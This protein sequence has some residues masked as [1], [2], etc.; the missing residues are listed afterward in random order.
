[1]RFRLR[2]LFLA[3][4][5]LLLDCAALDK[6]PETTCGN[7]VVD[8]AEDCDTFPS[9][10]DPTKPRCG[11]PTEGDFACHLHCG[12]ADSGANVCPAGWGCDTSG[13][14]REPSGQFSSALG[15]VS[16]GAVRLTVGDFDGDGRKDLVASGPRNPHSASSVRV[17]YFDDLGALAQVASLPTAVVSPAVFDHDHN[18]RDAIAFGVPAASSPKT[19]ASSLGVVSGLADRTF[20]PVVFPAATL[21]DTNAVPVFVFD[22][23]ADVKLP[24]GSESAIILFA[25]D[26]NGEAIVSLDAEL[27]GTAKLTR[28]LPATPDSIR[29]RPLTAR[30]FDLDATS[31]C[32]EIIVAMQVAPIGKLLVLSPCTPAPK[33]TA[34]TRWS[35]APEALKPFDLPA[36]ADTSR[37][38]LVADVDGD[39][40][41]DVLVDTNDTDGPQVLYGNGLTLEAPRKWAP[42]GLTSAL[43]MPLAA[44]DLN[45]DGKVDY[46]FPTYVAL[47]QSAAAA[48]AD[49]GADGGA[50][51]GPA[52]NRDGTLSEIAELQQTTAWADAV[53]G[54]FNGDPF[55]D[56][57]A[58]H[59]GAPD[60]DL[61]AGGSA[62]FTP[63]TV[64]TDGVVQAIARGDFDGDHVDDLGFTQNASGGTS[65]LSIA[66]GHPTGSL[67]PPSRIGSVDRA[68]GLA[69]LPHGSAPA[70]LGLY[71]VTATS[72][73]HP[74]ASTS[75]TL[76]LGSG[77]REPLALL[78][79]IDQLSCSRMTQPCMMPR[80][81]LSPLVSRQ[82]SPLSVLAGPIAVD[83]VSAVV[84]YAVGTSTPAKGNPDTFGVW[85]ANGDPGVPG[86]IAAPMEQQVLDGQYDA[87]DDMNRTAKLA[88]A[89]QDV[90]NLG[91]H[92]SEILAISNKTNGRDAALLVVRPG[93]T[94]A[95]DEKILTGLQ[96]TSSAQLEAIDLDGDGFRDAIGLF[97][98]PPNAQVVAFLNDG[99]GAFKVPGITLT[100]PP[101]AAGAVNDGTPVAFAGIAVRGSS[102]VTGAAVQNNA[103]AV[104][105]ASSVVLATLRPDKQGFDVQSLSSLLNKPLNNATGIA[106]GDF[107]GDGVEDIA[108]AD[109]GIRLILQKLARS[110]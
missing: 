50:D 39:G 57:A 51:A 56:F 78:F 49:G 89:I 64:T 88:T 102:A 34:G 109:G 73:A 11:A 15:F 83:G 6:L 69:V 22:H 61:F 9:S 82:W 17:H 24:N 33:A 43:K 95:G 29:G 38:V 21:P 26:K 18:G 2:P 46:V 81:P 58:I 70:D 101:P 40:H 20:L 54:R 8:A 103:L 37:G 76:L 44:G 5:V 55:A 42:A 105:T 75:L 67:E 30:L 74:I 91:D 14:C 35:L 48:G 97:G 68:R 96:V 100:I 65:T 106:A 31:A 25:Q 98:A 47:Q 104:L 110:K 99:K 85:V 72:A 94:P 107:N 84:T 108:I 80:Q 7:G 52:L 77:D 62:G 4:A 45:L 93:R 1:M 19:A 79:Y 90:D 53:I 13:M 71:A 12:V 60:I 59:S 10:T 32:G 87:Y 36:L 92:L 23:A 16:G 66:Y 86:G 28:A 63:S 41:L 3:L 27:G